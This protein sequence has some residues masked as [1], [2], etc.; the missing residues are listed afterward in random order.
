[1]FRLVRLLYAERNRIISFS[2]LLQIIARFDPNQDASFNK[3]DRFI[4]GTP[5]AKVKSESVPRGVTEVAVR[6]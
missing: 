4:A 2:S 1:M 3:V 5:D 6:K